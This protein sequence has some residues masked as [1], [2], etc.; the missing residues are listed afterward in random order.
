MSDAFAQAA[1]KLTSP[2][3]AER[4]AAVL[5]LF[6]LKD[7]RAIDLLAK[8]VDADTA[9]EV[10]YQARRAYYLLRDEIPNNPAEPFLELPDGISLDDLEKILHDE[11]PRIRHE[12]IVLAEKLDAGSVAPF[13]RSAIA[14]EKKIALQ[15][16]LIVAL[17]RAGARCDIPT[18]AAFLAAPEPRMRMTAIEAL[19]RIGGVEA[20]EYVVPLLRDADN[21]V[22]ALAA[23]VLEP[24][25]TGDMLKILKNLALAPEPASRDA[26]IFTLQ[27]YKAPQ[28]ARL[29][30]HL[31]L[32]D[33]DPGL[34]EKARA[35]LEAMAKGSETA[36]KV[37]ESMTR[38]PEPEDDPNAPAVVP[39]EGNTL[40][41]PP[42][43]NAPP[44][45]AAAAQTKVMVVPG[46][47]KKLVK[48]IW[49]GDP[50]QRAAALKEAAPLL[51]AEHLPF[52]LL[53]L[54]REDDPR[55][56]SQVVT[57][58]GKLHSVLA[59]A[60]I[61]KHFKHPD[62]RV[63]ANAI[64]AAMAIDPSTT[65]DRVTGFLKD[66]N[67][68]VRA[69]S[70]IACAT[71]PGFEPLAFVRDLASGDDPAWRRSALFVINRLKRP[72]FLEI[73]EFLVKDDDMEVRHL[74][75]KA[76][77]DYAGRGVKGARELAETAGKALAREQGASGKFDQDFHK[78][79]NEMRAPPPPKKVVRPGGKSATE[80]FGEQLLG[81]D[82][83]KQAGQKVKD[84]QA[85]AKVA[86]D[87]VK[88]SL[89][90]VHWRELP[91]RLAGNLPLALI[92]AAHVLSVTVHFQVGASCR[93]L[94]L[95]AAGLA[96]GAAGL[97]R[98]RQVPA[99]AGLLPLLLLF[100]PLV[101]VPLGIQDADLTGGPR[102]DGGPETG[103]AS[104]VAGLASPATGPLPGRP[105]SS[106]AVVKEPV[107][108]VEPP[109]GPKPKGPT[110][111]LL[112]P[113]AGTRISGDLL[114]KARIPVK[115]K[116]VEFF[117]EKT[118]LKTFENQAEGTCE[119]LVPA[120]DPLT[121]GRRVV[122]VVMTDETGRRT[123]DQAVVEVLKPLVRV[124]IGHPPDGGG[125]WRDDRFV[126][127]VTGEGCD[128]VEF[129]L[130]GAVIRSF[131]ADSTA[132]AA[133][134]ELP[135]PVATLSVGQHAF[136]V[137]ATMDDGRL[138]TDSVSFRALVPIPTVRF[139]SPKD[140]EEVFGQVQVV[141][142]ADSGWKETAIR[143]MVWY[144]DGVR[145]D[146]TASPTIQ[147]TWETADVPTGPHELV[148]TMVNELGRTASAT[149]R[150]N[151]IQPVFSVTVK[152]IAPG[153]VL[154]GDA[155]ATVEVV[156]ETP[157][158]K[159][160]RVTI[161][162]DGKP[163]QVSKEKSFLFTLRI[164]DLLPGK[165][166]L[167]VEAVRTDGKTAKTV[168]PVV[169]NP[170]DRRTV[171]FAA[172]DGAGRAVPVTDLAS[173]TLVVKEDGKAV[174]SYTLQ[175]AGA[176]P[177]RFGILL[178]QS[179]SMKE[180]QKL[181]LAKKGLAAFIDAL[182]PEDRA[183]LVTYSDT[184]QVAAEFTGE[185]TKLHQELEYLAPKRG[186]ALLDAVNLGVELANRAGGHT[187]LVLLADSG[188]EAVNGR[189][190]ASLHQPG[191]ILEFAKNA[192]VQIFTVSLGTLAPSLVG[193]AEAEL[194][195]LAKETGGRH[196][197][198]ANL[199]E[200]PAVLTG[201]M[202]EL[203][204]RARLSFRSPSGDPDGKWH[205]L[206]IAAPGRPDLRFLYKPGYQAR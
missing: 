184:A 116:T 180:D 137:R 196:L 34:K 163:Y 191:A 37:L 108:P 30:G 14:V 98:A 119:H 5:E 76:I 70:I 85:Q 155:M 65:P 102:Q 29:L 141:I 80:E 17:G 68:R 95:L 38:P 63:R 177:L 115:A 4:K 105:A 126:A 198:V 114:I 181:V 83:M 144:L 31:A 96:V 168:L 50:A 174:G 192:H 10:R 153:Q 147:A 27:R 139:V 39:L 182:R 172:A 159:I 78:A 127:T 130:D 54:D 194:R 22:R 107:P 46:L 71:R 146:A 89:A 6:G 145:K 23:K 61:I 171:F 167:A 9:A 62:D 109:D 42:D 101:A 18:L 135:V 112:E 113:A 157:G 69:S 165:R 186:S 94:S 40:P 193:D 3:E 32:N 160:D 136:E 35:A 150:V 179:A 128:Q 60:A 33:P 156:D 164:D 166:N 149:V 99:V 123:Q 162:L 183:F 125:Y 12:G 45:S 158:A 203:Q 189:A 118:H 49:W 106:P 195:A 81:R 57:L 86:T 187:A 170:R 58:I 87:K 202:R 56:L 201:L 154:T 161:S 77:S 43:P 1:A 121:P 205:T 199:G 103:P 138:A 200:L 111:K 132:S 197:R 178:D 66:P 169:A 28:A 117:F 82:G 90:T 110:V 2:Q 173:L 75:Y 41:A 25:D 100:A 11:N 120:G 74:A 64:D 97:G 151:L 19:N 152:G 48:S 47:P 91:A 36:R 148:V 44:G 175:P 140:T 204:G 133:R 122:K 73:L 143:E 26:A 206:E 188:D 84:L 51:R 88:E 67:N 55:A 72:A 185:P 104:T 134:F 16:E 15:A 129:L 24:L 142:E 8:R 21:R 52:L 53:R 7:P 131:P 59:Y 93:L 124:A 20:L 79:M 190:R 92:L 176:V 13:L